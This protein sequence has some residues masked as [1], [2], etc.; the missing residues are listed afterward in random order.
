MEFLQLR[1]FQ[2]VA[3]LEHMTKAAKELHVSQPALSKIIHR[4]EQDVGVELFDRQK[5]GIKLNQNGTAFLKRVDRIFLEAQQGKKEALDLA[6]LTER[7]VAVSMALP[8]ILP[9]FIAD[10]LKEYPEAHIKHYAASS[11]EMAKQLEEGEVDLCIS[12][13]PISG[14][15]IRWMFLMEEDIYLSVPL[16]HPLANRQQVKLSQVKSESFINRN[17]GYHFRELTDSFCREAGFEPFTQVELEEAGAILRMVEL[18]MGVS[19]TPQLSLLREA[20]PKTVQLKITEPLCKR[21]I[22]IAWNEDH[23]LTKAAKE[24][25]AFTIDFYEKAAKSYYES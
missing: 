7:S 16:N 21:E 8:H 19:F 14:K 4:L 9:V 5:Q 3:R 18:G 17:K 25:K 10:Y 6:N 1:Y 22:G 2:T 20:L 15:G 24:F 11:K 12:T 23:Y 13:S